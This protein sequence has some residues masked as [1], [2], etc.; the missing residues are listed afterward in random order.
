MK[1]AIRMMTGLVLVACAV[2]PAWAGADIGLKG[3]GGRVGYVDPESS[4]DGTIEFGLLMELGEFT[5]NLMWEACASYW[6]S[7]QDWSYAGRNYEW[8]VSDFAI[9]TG[10]NYHFLEGEFEPFAGGGVGVHFFSWD[11]AGYSGPV[12]NSDSDFGLYVDGG[13]EYKFSSQWHGEA[14]LRF[15]LA[16]PDQTGL[17]FSFVYQLGK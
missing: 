12:D 9:R 11:Y 3:I 2:M 8:S 16:D 13:A 15:D 4:L 7:G 17:L 5:D 14:M 10:V 1:Y 6:S